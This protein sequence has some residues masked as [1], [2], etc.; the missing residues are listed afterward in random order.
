M[1]IYYSINCAFSFAFAPSHLRS[2]H[3][4]IKFKYNFRLNKYSR[5]LILH[6]TAAVLTKGL[7]A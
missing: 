3:F 2:Q 7:A 5:R 4:E 6:E 1:L